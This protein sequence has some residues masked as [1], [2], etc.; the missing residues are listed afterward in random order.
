MRDSGFVLLDRKILKWQWYRDGNAKALL[1][2]LL[3]TA[4]WTD[5]EEEGV[6]VRRGQRLAALPTL[7]E[8]TGLSVKQLRTSIRKL[9]EGQAISRRFC[10]V[11]GNGKTLYTV[12]DYP[13]FPEE[14]ERPGRRRTGG[15]QA[16]GQAKGRRSLFHKKNNN[17]YNKGISPRD[18][19]EMDWKILE[20][21]LAEND[22][23][24]EE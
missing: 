4:N 10:R 19:A 5:G 24:Q 9:E 6:P 3:L 7:A 14:G 15:G 8:E 20:K 12:C 2:H 1:I 16:I 17:L 22:C 21:E 18:A 11:W 23:G 13:P